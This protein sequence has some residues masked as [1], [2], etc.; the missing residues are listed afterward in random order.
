MKTKYIITLITSIIITAFSYSQETIVNIEDKYNLDPYATVLTDEV[1]YF[2]DANNL[3]DKYTGTWTFNDG[4][5]YLKI[6]VTKHLHINRGSGNFDDLIYIKTEYKLNGEEKYN[7][8]GGIGGND[9]VSNNTVEVNYYEPSLTSCYRRKQG[10][11]QL[12]YSVNSSS[13]EQLIWTRT[14]IVTEGWSECPNGS[15]IDNSEF[16]IP[17]NLVLTKQ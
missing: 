6:V 1:F 13:I 8:S 3:L 12:E 7:T 16:L 11:L 4:I 10:N 15:A 9:I 17:A 14:N 2:K 5:H